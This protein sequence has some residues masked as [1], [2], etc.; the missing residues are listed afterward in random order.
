MGPS[1]PPPQFVARFRRDLE[2]LAGTPERLGLAVSGGPDSLALLLLAHEALPGAVEAATID[3]GLRAESTAEALHV[4]DIC[5]RVGV[6]HALLPVSVAAGGEG[7]QGEARRA[8]YA[9]LVDWAHASGMALIATGH[10]ADD[11]AETLLMRLRR[12]SGVGGLAGIRA[13]RIDQGVTIVRPLLGWSKAELVHLVAAAGLDPA[14]DPSNRDPRFDRTAMRRLLAAEDGFDP[15]RLART[16]AALAEADE[17]LDW[18]AEALAED[19]C[20]SAGGEWR[21]DPSGLPRELRRRLL[22]RAIGEVRAEHG[23][24]PAWSGNEDVEGLLVAL[25]S[26][27]AGTLAGIAARGGPVWHL[28]LAPPRRATG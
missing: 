11:Q 8:R 2:A 24:T 6:P 16:A 1:P 4:A 17:A 21:I 10:H 5:A 15:H 13:R 25:E 18:A 9:A 7:V 3:H 26:G 12:G 14:D 27:G 19:R 23:L 28:R 20:T 22:S